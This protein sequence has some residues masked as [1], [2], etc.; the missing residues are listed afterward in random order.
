MTSGRSAL[1]FEFL[2]QHSP[3]NN[4]SN[5]FY[6]KTIVYILQR[7]VKNFS[8]RRMNTNARNSLTFRQ[9]GTPSAARFSCYGRRVRRCE[10]PW[11]ECASP[12]KHTLLS[13]AHIISSAGH[14]TNTTVNSK[15][16]SVQCIEIEYR[17]C[18]YFFFIR[19]AIFDVR[20]RAAQQLR[21]HC[22]V[23]FSS[24]LVSDFH[25][26]FIRKKNRYSTAL[27]PDR[28]VSEY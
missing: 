25:F 14:D 12:S 22:F 24:Y 19:L 6:R 26:I 4:K 23:C 1:K 27:G 15:I 17:L 16:P 20:S 8:A 11:I 7:Y 21:R 18:T 2:C 28:P 13:F 10:L 5:P 3:G 9:Y